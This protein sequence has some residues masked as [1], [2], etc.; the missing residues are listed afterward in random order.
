[1]RTLASGKIKGPKGLFKSKDK[2]VE[3]RR[4]KAKKGEEKIYS[5][6]SIVQSKVFNF[7][8]LEELPKTKVTRKSPIVSTFRDSRN[9]S[10]RLINQRHPPKKDEYDSLQI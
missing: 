9:Q 1:M 8:F 2:K 10:P 7:Q 5:T 4:S 3:I 6:K